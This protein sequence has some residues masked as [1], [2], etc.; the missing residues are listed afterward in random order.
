M[1]SIHRCVMSRP[2]SPIL[3]RTAIYLGQRLAPR[4]FAAYPGLREQPQC[5]SLGLAPGRGYPFHSGTLFRMSGNKAGIGLCG[6]IPRLTADGC[7]PLPCSVEWGLSSLH[8]QLVWTPRGCLVYS[9]VV[10]IARR[11]ASHNRAVLGDSASIQPESRQRYLDLGELS[12]AT[13]EEA[14]AG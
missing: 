13:R 1:C 6:P 10:S 12:H 3:S 14:S 5:P 11:P 8:P 2:I 4:L 9:A 7:Y